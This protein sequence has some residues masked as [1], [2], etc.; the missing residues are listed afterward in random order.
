MRV[1]HLATTDGGGGASKFGVHL[2]RGLIATGGE[3]RMLVGRLEQPEPGIHAWYSAGHWDTHF[4]RLGRKLGLNYA[5]LP[6]GP[7]L[8]RHVDF[9][10]ADVL[11]VHNLHG[12]YINYLAMPLLTAAKPTV[13][14]VHDEWPFTGHCAVTAGCARWETGCGKCPHL[15]A[16]PAV[17]SDRTWL[18]WRLKRWALS[19]ASMH[20]ACPSEH[21]LDR[22]RRSHF[23]KHPL[24]LVPH[25]TD[26][27][28]FTPGSKADARERLGIGRDVKIILVAAQNLAGPRKGVLRFLEALRAVPET[29]RSNLVLLSF[30]N[31]S[32]RVAD[33]SP[34]PHISLGYLT[35][36]AEKR[37]AYCAADLY[38]SASLGESFGLTAL[39]AI[40]CGLPVA[41][42]ASGGIKDI[43]RPGHS[44][45]LAETGDWTGLI[46]A[47][48]RLAGDAGVRMS[49]SRTARQL[50]LDQF[51]WD[52][53]MRRYWAIYDRALGHGEK[54]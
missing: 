21:I 35:S 25:G 18:E 9:R 54:T 41:A 15:D 50:A 33:V 48:L 43:V 27:A 31:N 19:N 17:E 49:L 30:G 6:R 10:W 14:T 34:I 44:G 5:L 39:E 22:A 40:A 11:H 8:L 42:F 13:F 46:D 2:H 29:S 52:Q 16:Y 20:L 1:L 37:T 45:V 4:S 47:T 3:S 26:L 28:V 51:S 32:Q 7:E 24:H 53:M 23:S 38:V 12:G 36:D